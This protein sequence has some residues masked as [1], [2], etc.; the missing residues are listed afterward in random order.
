MRDPLRAYSTEQLCLRLAAAERRGDAAMAG[1][2]QAIF[3]ERMTRQ[4]KPPRTP[5]KPK[6]PNLPDHWRGVV[7]TTCRRHGV[8]ERDVLSGWRT[9]KV[10]QCRY[11]IWHAIHTRFGTSLV[12]IGVRFGGYDHTSIRHGVL[13]WQEQLNGQKQ[14]A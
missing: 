6:Q 12:R 5:P 2:L 7:T 1:R 8:H 11:E 4:R 10:V 9:P 14:A 13:R 3:D